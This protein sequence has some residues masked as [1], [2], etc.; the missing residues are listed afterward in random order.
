[1]LAKAM[2]KVRI[3]EQLKQSMK[4]YIEDSEEWSKQSEFVNQ[5]VRELLRREKGEITEIDENAVRKI[6]KEEIE[7]L[8]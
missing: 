8:N 4:E 5:A 7:G 2:A 3:D 6:V 1:M